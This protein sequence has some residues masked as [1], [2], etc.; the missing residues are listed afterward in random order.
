MKDVKGIKIAFLAYTEM[1]N[2]LES[3]MK[4]EDLD[5]MI[6]IINE[7][8]IFEDIAYAK[9][10]NADI[11]IASM[12]WGDEYAR[13]QAGRQEVLADKLLSAGVDIILGSHPH[14]IQPAQRM[15]YDGKTKYVIYSMGNFISNQRIET[16][17]PYGIGEETSKYTEDGV[18]VDINIE[19]NG[20]TGEVTI[21]DVGYIPLWVYKGTTADG[22]TEHVVYPIMEYIES[23]DINDKTK[24]RMQRSLKDTAMQ[25]K[26][27][28]GSSAE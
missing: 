11:I 20:E 21:K 14:V 25:M 1:V 26:V 22:G 10:K 12:H 24:A 6:N 8:K 4:P 15:E 16:L 2:G 27:L 19:K 23:N 17:V 7:E 5:S 18:I 28:Q 13:V 9:G 3:T